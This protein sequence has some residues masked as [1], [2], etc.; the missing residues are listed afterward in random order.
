MGLHVIQI[1]QGK[2]DEKKQKILVAFE[3]KEGY[4]YY[5]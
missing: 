1:M 5:I 3:G 2:N 4:F